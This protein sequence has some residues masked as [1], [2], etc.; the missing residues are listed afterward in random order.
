MTQRI[1]PT[2]RAFFERLIDYAGMFPPARL[3]LADALRNYARY[4]AEPEGWMLRSFVCGVDVLPLLPE[5]SDWFGPQRPLRIS[6]IGHPADTVDQAAAVAVQDAERIAS[7]NAEHRAWAGVDAVEIRAPRQTDDATSE[8]GAAGWVREL[9]ARLHEAGLRGS[10]LFIEPSLAGVWRSRV[11]TL[12]RILAEQN[13]GFP[14][15]RAGLKL[16]TGGLDAAA[17]P[18]VA[19]VAGVLDIARES[20]VALKFTAGLHHP[21]RQFDATVRAHTYGFLNVFAAAILG[22]TLRLD[23]PD[24]VAILEES[25]ARHFHF[26]ED[27]FGWN[28]ADA[29]ASE[30]AF[31]RANVAVSFGSCSFD[32]PRDG[33]RGLGW[34]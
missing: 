2:A 23:H 14:P 4:L 7:F 15:L 1:A 26:T 27:F 21:T 30:V 8:S 22:H 11:E 16:R 18:T 34:L 9:T 13:T 6:A 17:V 32:E 24:V 29:T 25:D 3:E 5:F 19:H 33:L 12:A 31:S 28:Q 20:G 10:S